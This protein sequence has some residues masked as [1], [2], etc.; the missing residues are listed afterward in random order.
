MRC[1]AVEG[2]EPPL[3]TDVG[4]A[5]L[6]LVPADVPIFD[7]GFDHERTMKDG[8]VSGLRAGSAAER[9][10]LRDGMRVSGWSVS[11]GRTETP[12]ELRVRDGGAERTISYLPLGA[13]VKGYRFVRR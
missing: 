4:P 6:A 3:P 5:E 12:V 7:T 13:P 11:F 9:A 2:I 8:V 10:G 1:W